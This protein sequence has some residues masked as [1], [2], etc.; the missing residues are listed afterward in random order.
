M[1]TSIYDVFLFIL[2]FKKTHWI[3]KWFSSFGHFNVMMFEMICVDT[4]LFFAGI[5]I[6]ADG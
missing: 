5:V 4:R 3:S 6:L 2:Q 1:F